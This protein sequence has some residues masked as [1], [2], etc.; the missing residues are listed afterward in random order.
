[1]S[2]INLYLLIIL[3]VVLSCG[4]YDRSA[5][6][7]LLSKI[8]LQSQ[9]KQWGI[10]LAEAR[11]NK[12]E[13]G[14][15]QAQLQLNYISELIKA[16]DKSSTETQRIHRKYK[17]L[18]NIFQNEVLA[19][20]RKYPDKK[21]IKNSYNFKIR[22]IIKN[23]YNQVY[24]IDESNF[25]SVYHP[26]AL[27]EVNQVFSD[28]GPLYIKE[29]R[30]KDDQSK[31]Q[32]KN[33]VA[34]TKPWS[35]F[36]YPFENHSLF[37]EDNSPFAK[38]DQLYAKL[39]LESYIKETE[40]DF[41][42]GFKPDAWEG[43]CDAWSAAAVLNKEPKQAKVIEGIEFSIADQKALLTFSHLKVN[44]V[45]YG[46]Q[47]QGNAETDGTYQDIMPE[48][49]HKLVGTVLGKEG[50][51]LIID[52]VAGVQVWNKPLYA[53]RWTVEQ[54]KEYDNIYN[55]KGYA[56]L[57]NQRRIESDRLTS[58]NDYLVRTY[59]YRLYVDTQDQNEDG[60]RVIAGQWINDSWKDHPDTVTYLPL[61][62]P[63]DYK[64]GSHNEEFD[65]YLS[66]FKEIF[67][68]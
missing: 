13:V 43:L 45:V 26:K 1:M 24:N 3:C 68:K 65:N 39:G 30:R 62:K 22:N 59:E 12:D 66:T 41:H 19:F 34:H 53:Y 14:Y 46:V 47:Y 5:K 28:F 64:L 63:G 52:D 33:I 21:N 17:I 42:K 37:K 60:Y 6:T 15:A 23:D 4:N 58:N 7:L 67:L 40:A 10:V 27:K 55:V 35:G 61:P 57:I 20:T 29:L 50:R 38:L 8:D 36:W 49:F 25:K 54:D 31:L 32:A 11:K 48:A 56:R 2:G 44:K 18:S 16:K 51:A 9:S